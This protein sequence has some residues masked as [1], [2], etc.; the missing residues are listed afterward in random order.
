MHFIDSATDRWVSR[1]AGSDA[2]PGAY[3]LLEL[4][5]WQVLRE[6]WPA[7]VPVGVAVP[8]DVDIETLADDLD[9]IGLVALSFP[10]WTDGRAYTQARLLRVRLRFTGQVRATGDV[11]VDMVPL[12]KRTGFDALQMR[13]GQSQAAAERVLTHFSGHYQGDVIEPRPLFARA[14]A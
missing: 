8:N 9:R 13:A 12:L 1:S 7:D 3:Q 2:E 14:A 5:D 6:R 10:K 11:L 4:A